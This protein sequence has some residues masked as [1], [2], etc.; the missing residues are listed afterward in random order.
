MKK[1]KIYFIALLMVNGVMFGAGKLNVVTTLT[2]YAN[3]AKYI[4][5]DKITVHSIV[6][7]DQDAHFVRPK[8]SYAVLLSKADL[9]VSTGL[10]LELWV[11][12]LVD[13]SKNDKIRSGQIGFVAAADGINLLEKPSVLSRSEGGLH[14]YGNPHITTNPLNYKI[15]ADNIEI[16]L[17]KN[18]PAN[19]DFYKANLKEFKNDIDIHVFG[20]KLVKLMG[21]KLLTKLAN[22][23]R[24][25][26]FLKSHEFKRVKMIDYLGGWLKEALPFRGKKIVA[27]H[28]NWVYFKQLFGVEIVGNVEPKPG[29]PP[30]PKHVE[31]LVSE[32]RKNNVKIVMAA[33]Y[34]DEKKV[35]DICNK[36]GAV[37]VI[38]PVYVDGA[39][40]TQ[41]VFKLVNL[42][43]TKLNEAVVKAN[44]N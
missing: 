21:G 8:P 12:T 42:W 44:K 2:T 23:G 18:D 24:L 17:E 13:M 28:K 41:N 4:G 31:E 26:E 34:F 25:I 33:N 43:I 9:F 3:I 27:Y 36:V 14:I 11:P 16:G 10:D 5:K 35:T 20:E 15:I 19:A 40:N 7:G 29:I 6:A 37:P 32:M 1:L 39:P 22:N 30:S 38:V